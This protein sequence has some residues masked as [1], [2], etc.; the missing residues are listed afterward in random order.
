MI[1]LYLTNEIQDFSERQIK[2][3]I[4]LCP[5]DKI[6][7]FLPLR[8]EIYIFLRPINFHW[9]FFSQCELMKIAVFTCDKLTKL[10][11]VLQPKKEIFNY[12]THSR[13]SSWFFCALSKKFMI[14]LSLIV[15]IRDFSCLWSTKFM[16]FSLLGRQNSWFF[17]PDQQNW[18][19][20]WSQIDKLAIFPCLTKNIFNFYALDQWNSWVFLHVK[21]RWFFL[22]WPTKCTIFRIP[23]TKFVIFPCPTDD[24]F[25]FSAPNQRN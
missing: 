20:F 9:I 10:M 23:L 2:L 11:I 1:F 15:K 6:A 13:D 22:A 18:T 5:I 17:M 8:D 7:F 4:F 14:F 3:T 21:P 16:F 24:I 19:I 25:N 12:S